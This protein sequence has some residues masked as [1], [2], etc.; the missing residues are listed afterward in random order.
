[1]HFKDKIRKAFTPSANSSPTRDTHASED[2]VYRPAEPRWPSNVYRW[3]EP[4]PR[5]KYRGPVKVEHKK[6]LDSYTLGFQVPVATTQGQRR[7][8][9]MSDHSPMSSRIQSRR[10]SIASQKGRTS[11]QSRRASHSLRVRTSISAASAAA[12]V[13]Q[14]TPPSAATPREHKRHL[15]ESLFIN[16]SAANSTSSSGQSSPFVRDPNSPTYPLSPTKLDFTHPN[17]TPRFSRHLQADFT[18]APLT[19]PKSPHRRKDLIVDT[20]PFG[21]AQ[22]RALT[23]VDG[24]NKSGSVF[25]TQNPFA[26]ADQQ[27]LTPVTPGDRFGEVY[28]H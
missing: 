14:H 7:R 11:I 9:H 2:L 17:G 25:R 27:L 5:L 18:G 21:A 16:P 12:M 20:T 24:L 22:S 19:P 23:G 26:A 28:A 6:K 1:M 13:Q 10:S 8:S 4:L 15:R 3:D